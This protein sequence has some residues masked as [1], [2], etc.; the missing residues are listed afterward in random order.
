MSVSCLLYIDDRL[1]EEFN[2]YL[3]PHIG[4]ST[5]WAKIAIHSAVK[6][7]VSLG[8]FYIA[9]SV[10]EPVHSLVFLGMIIDKEKMS[11]FLTKKR[12]KKLKKI[13]QL[14]LQSKKV[15]VTVIQYRSLYVSGYT[16]SKIVYVYL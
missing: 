12:K 16:W 8:Y 3:L 7:F 2:G 13:R 9:K 10:L 1:I 5:E 11:F 15:P 4:N 6:W 14:I